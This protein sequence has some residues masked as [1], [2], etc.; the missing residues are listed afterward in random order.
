[1][2]SV[3]YIFFAYNLFVRKGLF[4]LRENK[5]GVNRK[6]ICNTFLY[7]IHA[8]GRKI[9]TEIQYLVRIWVDIRHRLV[10]TD[11]NSHSSVFF[12]NSLGAPTLSRLLETPPIS[13][14]P[15]AKALATQSAAFMQSSATVPAD[16]KAQTQQGTDRLSKLNTK[17]ENIVIE[18]IFTMFNA[19]SKL[20]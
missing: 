20:Q 16:K 4:A 12:W 18:W 2:A 7:A 5:I 14:S 17:W 15:A 6:L 8:R 13:T 19:F 11:L 1:M 3:V 9:C 10:W